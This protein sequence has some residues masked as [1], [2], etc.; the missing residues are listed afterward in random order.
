M[1]VEHI[2]LLTMDNVTSKVIKRKKFIS[3]RQLTKR[4]LALVSG[5]IVVP[6]IF[7]NKMKAGFFQD[8]PEERSKSFA[9]QIGKKTFL[10]EEFL[11]ES[12]TAE[13]LFHEHAEALPIIDYHCHLP[14][15]EISSNRR[16]QNLTQIW[17]TGDHYKMRVMRANGIEEKYITGDADDYVKFLKWAETVPYTLRNPLF[18]WTHLELKRYFGIDTI[19]DSTTA[20]EVYDIA[21]SLLQ[22]DKFRTQNLIKDKNVEIICTTD[23]PIDKL[24]YHQEIISQGY[25]VRVL[26]TWRPD[27]VLAVENAENFNKYLNNLSIVSDVNISCYQDLIDA[28]NRRQD[29]F[30]SMGCKLSD[31][32]LE[33]FFFEEYSDHEIK[34]IFNKIRSQKKLSFQEIQ[35]FKTALLLQLCEMNFQFGWTQQFHVGALRNN[36]TRMFK[37]LGPDKG[38]DSMGDFEF[39]KSMAK[40]LDHLEQRQK[41][42]KTIVYNL[43]PRDNDLIISML[44]NFNDGVIPGKMQYG[45]AWWFLDQKDGIEKQLNA[46]SNHGLL[47]R[48]IGML[49]DSRSFL[50]FPRHEYFRR[51]LCNLIANDVEKGELPTDLKWLGKVIE[52]ICYYNAKSYLNF[53]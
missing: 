20:K 26:P 30:R 5:L 40:F 4:T 24:Q 36:N 11:L 12:K 14:P 32:G 17:L 6:E 33:S 37:S 18:H 52:D 21:T 35:K 53:Q 2:K 31:H 44:C 28:L 48:F 41:L 13:I 10:N 19:L 49:T 1:K 42:T 39:A 50:S 51:I 22:T 46:L 45:S 27:K 8:N 16:F 34:R 29:F 43:N 9:F 3:R 47:S 38:F 7:T 23:D 15:N 25:P